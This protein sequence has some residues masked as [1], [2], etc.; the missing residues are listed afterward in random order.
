MAWIPPKRKN[1]PQTP[2]ELIETNRIPILIGAVIFVATLCFFMYKTQTHHKQEMVSER[3]NK[4][5]MLVRRMVF[6]S[7]FK[8]INMMI[9]IIL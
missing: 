9:R 3:R 2:F 1:I 6:G 5:L 7:G 8:M 4:K